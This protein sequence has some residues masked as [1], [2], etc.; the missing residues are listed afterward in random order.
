MLGFGQFWRVLS[1]NGWAAGWRG[2]T[3]GLLPGNVSL[4]RHVAVV[5]VVDVDVFSFVAAMSDADA[6]TVVVAP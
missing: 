3:P 5:A 6:L 1:G 2:Q 4:H